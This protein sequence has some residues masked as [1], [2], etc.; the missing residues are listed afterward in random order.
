MEDWSE[1]PCAAHQEVGDTPS[2]NCVCVL[3]FICMCLED[4]S[5]AGGEE[6]RHADSSTVYEEVGDGS[7]F[8]SCCD[9]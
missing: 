4:C 8:Q 5:A 3:R 2:F 6:E 9:F 7:K 1:K